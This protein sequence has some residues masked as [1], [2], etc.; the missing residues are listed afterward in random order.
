MVS[1]AVGM[2]VMFAPSK[3]ADTL[4]FYTVIRRAAEGLQWMAVIW[5]LIEMVL[6]CLAIHRSSRNL[7][8]R[9]SSANRLVLLK[10]ILLA[11]MLL[12]LLVVKLLLIRGIVA[13]PKNKEFLS[14]MTS[15][16]P[17][18][19]LDFTLMACLLSLR[20][21]PIKKPGRRM[22]RLFL[23]T[24][25]MVGMIVLGFYIV[26]NQQFV[27]SLVHIA[28]AG[29]HI[30][31][32]IHL[33]RVGVFPNHQAEGYQTFWIASAAIGLVL[34]AGLLLLL[35]ASSKRLAVR[36]AAR[37]SF[38]A[39]VTLVGTYVFWFAQIE[40]PRINPEMASV[41]WAALWP[42]RVAGG[43]FVLGLSF[44]IAWSLV[45]FR[46]PASCAHPVAPRISKLAVMASLGIV[47]SETWLFLDGAGQ[48][49]SFSLL[50]TD[51]LDL[52]L[53][54]LESIG[55]LIVTPDLSISL[56][57]IVGGLGVVGSAIRRTGNVQ[58]LPA[59]DGREFMVYFV[60]AISFLLVAIPAL[61]AFGFCWWLGP[62]I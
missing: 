22:I 32:P 2:A 16:W 8:N 40:F 13:Y 46:S 5:M 50:F 52:L 47:V 6:Q 60:A 23:D 27:A 58:V 15:L 44:A 28:I 3:P 30:A 36:R 55:Y 34:V 14:V 37:I 42:D 11:A 43:L 21:N 62:F 31:N 33:R 41:G 19:L 26:T 53:S 4:S 10:R 45:K 54:T 38:A 12:S 20:S 61:A 1:I 7:P 25:V 17:N 59:I 39:I 49:F 48:F 57:L 24:V 29:I 51:P 18:V 56:L 35:D 9:F